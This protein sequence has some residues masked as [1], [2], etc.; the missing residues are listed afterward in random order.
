MSIVLA[1][2]ALLPWYEQ[3]LEGW[4]Y[5]Q[6]EGAKEEMTAEEAEG[7]VVEE[8][9]RLKELLALA[10]LNPTQE[11]V[12]RYM[13]EERRWSEQSSEFAKR[14]EEILAEEGNP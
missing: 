9:G 12:A 1:L 3:K 13:Q 10:L 4:Y 5:F 14:W 2:I 8:K 6:E 7:I 11:N